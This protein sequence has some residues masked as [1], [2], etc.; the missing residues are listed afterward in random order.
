MSAVCLASLL[1][2]ACAGILLRLLSV[3]FPFRLDMASTVLCV[4]PCALDDRLRMTHPG[5]VSCSSRCEIMSSSMQLL[6]C[7]GVDSSSAVAGGKI[8]A[9]VLLCA[10]AADGALCREK[11]MAQW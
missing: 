1:R 3:S 11:R 7:A 4:R 2:S 10:V 6:D 9:A 8:A 5:R